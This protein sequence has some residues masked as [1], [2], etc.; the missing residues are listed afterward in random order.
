M[1]V[2]NLTPMVKVTSSKCWSDSTV[3]KQKNVTMVSCLQTDE[4]QFEKQ[5]TIKS[6]MLLD[7]ESAN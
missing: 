5:R 1:E 2:Q 7:D 3:S 6:V 4:Q